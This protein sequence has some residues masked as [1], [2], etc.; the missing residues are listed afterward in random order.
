MAQD[1]PA[2]LEAVHDWQ[3]QVDKDRIE[4]VLGLADN[5]LE[6][7]KSVVCGFNI[8]MGL[9]LVADHLLQGVVVSDK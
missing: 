9:Q 8:K 3:F 6:G 7:F 2:S 1:F 4:V 5:D